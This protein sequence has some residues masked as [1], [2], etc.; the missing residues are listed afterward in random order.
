MPLFIEVSAQLAQ[1]TQAHAAAKI[2][3]GELLAQLRDTPKSNPGALSRAMALV[4]QGTPAPF[5]ERDL[6]C[7]P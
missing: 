2:E 5:Q 7:P 3:E 1:L 6:I 4:T